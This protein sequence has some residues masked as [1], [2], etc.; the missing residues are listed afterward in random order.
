MIIIFSIAIIFLFMIII[1]AKTNEK[2]VV[3]AQ[4]W[5]DSIV[6]LENNRSDSIKFLTEE[7]SILKDSIKILLLNIK[8]LNKVQDKKIYAE[9]KVF[10]KNPSVALKDFDSISVK[11][12]IKTFPNPFGNF[13][14]VYVG[15]G[16]KVAKIQIFNV[17]NGL[18]LEA[19]NPENISTEKLSPGVYFV[20]TYIQGYDKV[21]KIERIIKE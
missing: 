14:T 21:A 18:T 2:K 10:A 12:N 5:N 7:N 9:K 1:A 13:I 11:R 16:Y 19:F 6:S 17:A 8:N 15:D 3:F 4:R 20:H